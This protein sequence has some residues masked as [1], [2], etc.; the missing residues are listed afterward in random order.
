M[1]PTKAGIAKTTSADVAP[2]RSQRDGHG[3]P[4]GVL[5]LT[6]DDG[7][8]VNTLALGEYLRRERVSAT[9]FVIGGWKKGVSSDPGFG[10]R[11]YETGHEKL[12]L[13][14]DLVALGHR[15]G[16]HIA[17]KICS[18]CRTRTYDPAVNSRLLYQ[19]S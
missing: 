3:F 19:L 16:N 5:A 11:V 17:S 14:A 9:F 6:W 18:G 15:V 7:P 2:V 8:D 10:A 13:L 1:L 4:E 12:P